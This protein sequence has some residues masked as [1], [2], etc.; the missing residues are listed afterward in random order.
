MGKPVL[1]TELILEAPNRIADGVGGY[2]V[3]WM[4]VGTH[5]AEV[6]TNSAGERVAGGR[7]TP[8]TSHRIT[9]RSAPTDS[10]RFPKADCRFRSGG[11]VFSIRG[12]APAGSREQYLTCWA[13]E[14]AYA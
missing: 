9:I 7:S 10:P 14:G 3:A 11:R 8:D 1:N 2:A 12:I 4:P 6:R 5:W 13:E